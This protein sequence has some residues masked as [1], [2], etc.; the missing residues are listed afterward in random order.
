MASPGLKSHDIGVDF[1]PV[2]LFAGRLYGPMSKISVDFSDGIKLDE[3]QSKLVTAAV[4]C[5]PMMSFEND[6]VP[7][8]SIEVFVRTDSFLDYPSFSGMTYVGFLGQPDL[9]TSLLSKSSFNPLQVE[10]WRKHDINSPSHVYARGDLS[11]PQRLMVHATQRSQSRKAGK[12]ASGAAASKKESSLNEEVKFVVALATPQC[13]R[14]FR[15]DL[16]R[17]IVTAANVTS[18][19]VDIFFK[20]TSESS[21]A[22][23][24]KSLTSKESFERRVAECIKSGKPLQVEF[25]VKERETTKSEAIPSPS[26]PMKDHSDRPATLPAYQ[27]G[28]RKLHSYLPS[29]GSS[30][31]SPHAPLLPAV[32][33]EKTTVPPVPAKTP[34]VV[35]DTRSSPSVSSHDAGTPTRANVGPIHNNLESLLD[36]FASELNK[37]LLDNFGSAAT[38]VGA[39]SPSPSDTPT[40]KVSTSEKASPEGAK[41]NEAAPKTTKPLFH[42]AR[43]DVCKKV[44][45]GTRHKCEY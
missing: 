45:Q 8:D 17:R 1:R 21:S 18:G 6:V 34:I 11:H 32:S 3:L 10:V 40:P 2:G 36:K 22:S 5:A 33:A 39:S 26:E 23:V 41:V 35:R 9:V 13:V 44:I 7:S 43:C 29:F 19:H 15:K 38:V 20:R 16:E 12:A 42:N 4:R 14:L 25:A 31:G 27:A 24:D 30:F 28:S 37:C